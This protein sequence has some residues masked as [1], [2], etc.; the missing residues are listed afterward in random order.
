MTPALGFL[1]CQPQTIVASK[2]VSAKLSR[3]YKGLKS[4]KDRRLPPIAHDGSYAS[5]MPEGGRRSS[6]GI[7]WRLTSCPEEH[8]PHDAEDQNRKSGGDRK[9]CKYRRTRL[10]L[11]R[12]G[13]SFNDVP[14]SSRCHGNLIQPVP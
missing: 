7:E 11:A 9:Q 1:D 3:S 5:K 8:K 12:F 10:A 4:S 14:V 13:R 2:P 6:T